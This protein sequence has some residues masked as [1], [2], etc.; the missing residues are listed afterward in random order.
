[1]LLLAHLDRLEVPAILK[2][3]LDFVLKKSV[4]LLEEMLKVA[5]IPRYTP[6]GWLTP[7]IACVEMLQCITQAVSI[8]SRKTF[9]S[10][11]VHLLPQQGFNQGEWTKSCQLVLPSSYP[12]TAE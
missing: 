7:T 9:T 4:L 11:K 6:Y 8:G 2:K 10:G 12:S 1:M 5:N 3:D